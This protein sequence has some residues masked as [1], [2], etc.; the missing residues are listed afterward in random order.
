MPLFLR[1]ALICIFS[2]VTASF[3]VISDNRV[4]DSVVASSTEDSSSTVAIVDSSTV[5][6]EK[7]VDESFGG[8]SSLIDEVDSRVV[9]S[10][11]VVN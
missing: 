6:V 10:T 11:L 3:P 2:P 5:F 7:V 9:D 1:V 8:S 4:V